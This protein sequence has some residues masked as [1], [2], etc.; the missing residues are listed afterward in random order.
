MAHFDSDRGIVL[1]GNELKHESPK[2][3]TNFWEFILGE[4]KLDDQI[5]KDGKNRIHF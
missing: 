2:F 1:E 4:P 3:I 5:K